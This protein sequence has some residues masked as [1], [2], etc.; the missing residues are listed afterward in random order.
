MS[1]RR[2]NWYVNKTDLI[3]T[4]L[5]RLTGR[6]IKPTNLRRCNDVANG[7]SVRLTNLTLRRDVSTRTEMRLTSM[8]RRIKVLAGIFACYF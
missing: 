5:R 6:S 1:L 8:R 7:T 3:W 2:L 4:S